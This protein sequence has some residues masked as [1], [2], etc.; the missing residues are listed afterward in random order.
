MSAIELYTVGHSTRSIDEFIALL[1]AWK[2]TG[3]ADVRSSPWSRFNPQFNRDRIKDSLK[4]AQI[5]YRFFGKQLGGRPDD[6]KMFRGGVADYEAMAESAEFRA[7]LELAIAGA[8]K[9]R[10]ALMCSEHDPI[11][12]H[13]CL[14]VGR[15]LSE[16]GHSIYH[17]TS[18]SDMQSQPEIET[19]ILKLTGHNQHDFLRQKE[20]SL[21]LAYREWS[22]R[23]AYSERPPNGAADMDDRLY[24]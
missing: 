18:S 5:Q 11:E 15:A 24:G 3:L 23:V 20:P 7:G 10:L 4:S 1:E 19:K 13:R 8:K 14:L 21:A 2:I 22:G 16:L 12:C 6:P 9:H 17:I